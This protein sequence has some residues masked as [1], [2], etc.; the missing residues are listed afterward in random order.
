[1]NYQIRPAEF[2][3]LPEILKIYK[4][5]RAFMRQTGN[6]NQWWD[7]HPAESILREDIPKGQL[8][9]YETDGQIGAVFAYIQGTD[10]TY[11]EIDGPGWLND[12]PYGVIHRI[13]VA[14]RGQGIIARIFDWALERCPNLRIDTH[15]DNA[16]MRRALEKY[17]F[18]YCG[19]IH[20]F[21]GDERIA[22][23]KAVPSKHTDQPYYLSIFMCLGLSI[24]LAIGAG[25]G[26]IPIGMCFG[27]SIGVGIGALLDAKNRKDQS[28]QPHKQD[29]AK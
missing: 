8:Y 7:Y 6:P 26:N 18:T 10:P 1:M 29:K 16:P 14:Q 12:E 5:A 11:L 15:V 25:I 3:D 17:G 13:A 27:M 4:E 23:H 20:I 24:G 22:F 28:G 9:V 19:I 21:N 2:S